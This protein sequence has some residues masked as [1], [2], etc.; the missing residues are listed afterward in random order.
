MKQNK[1]SSNTSEV[2][3]GL[4]P[5]SSLYKSEHYGTGVFQRMSRV[6]QP[7]KRFSDYYGIKR[8]RTVFTKRHHQT[9]SRTI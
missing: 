1:I 3:A 5:I 7:Y 8:Y 9:Q 2:G 4:L 6:T